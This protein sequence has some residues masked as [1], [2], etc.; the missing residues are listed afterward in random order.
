MSDQN[1]QSEFQLIQWGDVA[2]AT[3]FE[4]IP[5]GTYNGTVVSSECAISNNS[6]QPMW[7]L[8]LELTDEGKYQG[9][10]LFSHLSFSEKALPMTKA[11]LASIAP[12]LLEIP[13]FDPQDDQLSERLIGLHVSIKVTTRQ[14]EGEMRN[15]VRSIRA[16]VPSENAFV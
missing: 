8:E 15:N 11:T 1:Q 14:Y 4:P 6:G 10:K 9:R 16:A 3:G 2:E 12:D 13:D 7:T 5:R